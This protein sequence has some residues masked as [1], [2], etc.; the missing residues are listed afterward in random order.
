MAAHS[1]LAFTDAWFYGVATLEGVVGLL[2]SDAENRAAPGT[3]LDAVLCR[4]RPCYASSDGSPKDPI[5][6]AVALL[7]C[8]D[9]SIGVSGWRPLSALAAHNCGL[10]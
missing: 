7:L 2:R 8:R 4:P 1:D 10:A 9:G 6:V 3:A 5:R